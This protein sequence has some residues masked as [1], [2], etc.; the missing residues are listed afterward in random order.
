MF[1]NSHTGPTVEAP[2]VR[3]RPGLGRKQVHFVVGAQDF[4]EV[5]EVCVL[6]VCVLHLWGLSWLR[7]ASDGEFK[8]REVHITAF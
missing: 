5:S 2:P 1:G 8:E 7:A 3:I 6:E 4:P